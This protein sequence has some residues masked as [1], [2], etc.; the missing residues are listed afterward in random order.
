[1]RMSCWYSWNWLHSLQ[2]DQDQVWAQSL[3]KSTHSSVRVSSGN[4]A[5]SVEMAVPLAKRVFKG[6]NAW[7][8]R[9]NWRPSRVRGSHKGLGLVRLLLAKCCTNWAISSLHL[10]PAQPG[11][12]SHIT[13]TFENDGG[14]ASQL[15]AS[16]LGGLWLGW[17]WYRK[18]LR[19]TSRYIFP[20][21]SRS[22]CYRARSWIPFSH[23]GGQ[24]P[25]LFVFGYVQSYAERKWG[26][27][28]LRVGEYTRLRVQGRVVIL[29]RLPSHL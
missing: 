29:A 5:S 13:C 21:I 14:L 18:L 4:A 11:W 22:G 17:H 10:D 12:L 24:R 8:V 25:C 9:Q 2:R 15:L 23:N 7:T 16:Q 27:R 20:N 3:S 19:L 26:M 28:R 6:K 1:M